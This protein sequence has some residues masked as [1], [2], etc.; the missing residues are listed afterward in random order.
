M[1]HTPGP[2]QRFDDGGKINDQHT[3]GPEYADCVWGPDG[4]GHGVIADCSPYG[5]RAT[6]KTIANA[7]L[8]AA[9]PKLLDALH[10]TQRVLTELEGQW[11]DEADHVIAQAR[12]VIAE[13]SPGG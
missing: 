6:E 3:Y 2:W 5:Q 9:A 7:R 8:I 4:P 10:A 11:S 12:S 13:A 1:K